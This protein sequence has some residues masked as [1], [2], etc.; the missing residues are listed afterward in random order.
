MNMYAHVAV[1]SKRTHIHIQ[2]GYILGGLAFDSEM[3]L[4]VAAYAGDG[5]EARKGAIFRVDRSLA[6]VKN[7][8]AK[9]SEMPIL[10][11]KRYVCM[12]VFIYTTLCG[13]CL[14]C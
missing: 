4:Y 11:G 8:L 1:G 14:F 3:S 5:E 10:L 9:L 7:Q 12:N 13:R 2:D 6:V